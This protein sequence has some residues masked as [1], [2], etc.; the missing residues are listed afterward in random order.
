MSC[1]VAI[2]FHL[3]NPEIFHRSNKGSSMRMFVNS[4]IISNSRKL[5][6]RVYQ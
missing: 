5:N 6:L 3:Y 4:V 1:D 2:H